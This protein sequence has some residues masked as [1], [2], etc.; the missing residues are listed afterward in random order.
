MK[1]IYTFTNAPT[2]DLYFT[3]AYLPADGSLTLP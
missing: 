2:P 3:A 1:E